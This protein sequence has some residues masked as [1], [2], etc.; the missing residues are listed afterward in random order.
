MLVRF[1]FLAFPPEHARLRGG[2]HAIFSQLARCPVPLI[3]WHF[4]GVTLRKV[5]LRIRISMVGIIM[6]RTLLSIF[7]GMP[8][9]GARNAQSVPPLRKRMARNAF[10]GEGGPVQGD[11][12]VPLSWPLCF[13]GVS[14]AH[15]RI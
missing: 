14:I 9:E 10:A 8:D 4:P 3:F 5:V 6:S 1:I 15:W 11:L 13:F 2:G 12:H 7:V